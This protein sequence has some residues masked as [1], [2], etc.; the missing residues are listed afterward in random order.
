MI[1]AKQRSLRVGRNAAARFGAQLW[2]KLLALILAPLIIRLASVEVL[3]QYLMA[4]TVVGLLTAAT[5]CGLSVYLT[6]E[7]AK[8]QDATRQRRLLGDILAL[9]G[10]LAILGYAL[11]LALGP[12]LPLPSAIR[13]IL[14]LAGLAVLPEAATTAIHAF[15]NA[16]QRMDLSSGITAVARLVETLGAV[17]AL[18]RPG[19]FYRLGDLYRLGGTARLILWHVIGSGVGAALS[20]RILWRRASLPEVRLTHLVREGAWRRTL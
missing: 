4:L 3:G 9:K 19:D 10:V 2:A 5:D 11:L 12:L 7:G 16:R 8:T 1:T 6:R 17:A 18:A 20:F 13:R 15:F 14:P